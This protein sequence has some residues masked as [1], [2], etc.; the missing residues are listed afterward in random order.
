MVDD[1]IIQGGI[2][3]LGIWFKS[4]T[5]QVLFLININGNSV[6]LKI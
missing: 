1:V 5:V 6:L 2:G 3:V 4:N